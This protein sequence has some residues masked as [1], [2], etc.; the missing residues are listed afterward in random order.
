MIQKETLFHGLHKSNTYTT[1]F[2]KTIMQIVIKQQLIW[3][4]KHKLDWSA[5]TRI[6][7]HT[8][9]QNSIFTGEP[10]METE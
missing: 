1:K 3:L 5:I 4:I 7:Q 10:T 2:R 8:T 9:D 6:E